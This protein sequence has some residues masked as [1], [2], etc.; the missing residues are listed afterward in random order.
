MTKLHIS[1]SLALPL[2]DFVTSTQAILAKKGKGKSYTA[3][4]QAEELLAAHQQ[5][6]VVDPT[7]AWHGLRSSADGK[8]PGYSIAVLG[9]EHGDVPLEVTAGEVIGEAIATEH[10]SAILDLSLFRKAEA[11]RFM[12]VLLETLYRK[13]RDALHLFIDEADTVAPQKPFG[14]EARTLGATEDIVRRGRIRGIGCTLITQRP[15]VLNKNVLSQVDM[16]TTLGMNHP[17]DIAAIREWVAV[18]GDEDKAKQMIS[19]L[20]SLP[21]G[22]AWIWAPAVDLFKHVTIRKRHTFDSG[23]T[24]KAGERAVAP[25]VLADVDIARLG[26]A[27]AETAERA[28]AADPKAL[29]ARVA[30]LEKQLAAKPSGAKVETK[31]VDKP[32]LKDAQIRDLERAFAAGDRVAARLAAAADALGARAKD[33]VAELGAVRA[34]VARVIDPPPHLRAPFVKSPGALPARAPDRPRTSARATIAAATGAANARIGT[35]EMKVLNAVA[36]WQSIGI[37]SPVASAVAFLAGYTSTSSSFER[38]RGALRTA[39]LIEFPTQGALRMTASG[40]AIAAIPETPLDN[41]AMHAAVM[42]RLDGPQ[43]KVLQPVIDA[44]PKPVSQERAAELAG[45]S[46]TSSSF[47]RARGALRTFGLIDFPRAGELRATDLL[48]PEGA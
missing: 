30:E 21:V 14:D 42:A 1:P 22:Q 44:Y 47:E 46:H 17:K 41:A 6:V 39:G 32:V 37:E 8:S 43:R 34:A 5:I 45:Y 7:G 25:K 2:E 48:F 31:V 29:R 26:S 20:P 38:A 23:R 4:V 24:P 16:L 33:L 10:F 19:E 36:W 13:N 18:H 12:G 9:G 27:I 28:K 3:S 35:P 40:A 11:N 15:Q